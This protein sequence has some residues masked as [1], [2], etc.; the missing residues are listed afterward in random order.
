MVHILG[1]GFEMV[2]TTE[3]PRNLFWN[4]YVSFSIYSRWRNQRSTQKLVAMWTKRH[5]RRIQS[6]RI[7]CIQGVLQG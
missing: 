2:R 1:F 5:N 3:L 7:R 6:S 4:G